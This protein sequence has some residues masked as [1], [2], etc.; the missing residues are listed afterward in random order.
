MEGP[1]VEG[2][3]EVPDGTAAASETG[4]KKTRQPAGKT[5]PLRG[6]K[7]QA[8][9]NALMTTLETARAIL[10]DR[11]G[12]MGRPCLPWIKGDRLLSACDACYCVKMSCKTSGAEDMG[13]RGLEPTQ[14]V[15]GAREDEEEGL[16]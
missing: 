13:G 5:A 7:P 14:N 12:R 15:V 1:E 6:R 3:G 4:K 16:H 8:A 2:S 10:C 11:C 9:K